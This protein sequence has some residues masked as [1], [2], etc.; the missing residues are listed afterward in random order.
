MDKFFTQTTCDRCGG[1][2]AKGRTMS[3]YSTECICMVCA[4]AERKRKDYARVR[5]RKMISVWGS[6]R[7][8]GKTT[9]AR[10]RPKEPPWRRATA[11]S[12]AWASK[13]RERATGRLRRPL[14]Q[15]KT[16]L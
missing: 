12:R 9:R 3:M 4:E 5:G 15:R 10:A 1:T 7:L 6:N 13:E 11:T 14:A 8:V 2:L 16:M